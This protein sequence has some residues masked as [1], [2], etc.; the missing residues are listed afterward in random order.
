MQHRTPSWAHAFLVSIF[1][2]TLISPAHA[3]VDDFDGDS[4]HEDWTTELV[5][6]ATGYCCGVSGGSLTINPA[7]GGSW[8]GVTFERPYSADG[9]FD[10]SAAWSWTTGGYANIVIGV[11]AADGSEMSSIFSDSHT[12]C[13]GETFAVSLDGERLGIGHPACSGSGVTSIS[14]TGD[15]MTV[16]Y[17]GS[18]G[19]AS[20][21]RVFTV[22]IVAVQLRISEWNWGSVN[23]NVDR[24]EINCGHEPDADGDGYDALACG[25]FDC[26]DDNA[27]VY[28]DA[29]EVCDEVDNDCDGSIDEDPIDA[30]TWY[31]DG[32]GDGF[33]GPEVEAVS[34][35]A[36][37]GHVEDDTDCNDS[38]AS[39]SP[40]ADEVCDEVDNDC[41][42][43]TDEDDA[44]D[45]AT[46]YADADTD[47][48]GDGDSPYSACE[49]PPGFLAD[50]SD[51]DDGDDAVFPGADEA[52]DG[53]DNDCDGVTD[54]D[55]ASD[56]P[57]WYADADGD[58]YGD[59][60]TSD[61]A[62]GAPADHVADAT[63]C[64]DGVSTTFPGADEICDGVD[65]DC[66]GTTDGAGAIDAPTWYADHDGDGY[67]ASD[68]TVASCDEP[69]G[70][71][72]DATDCDDLEASTYPGADETCD[73]EDNDCD[74]VTDEEGATDVSTWYADTDGDGFG[75]AAVTHTACSLPPGHV[76]D[77]TDCDD[78]ESTTFPGADETCD[79]T[80]ND[81]D[82]V[83]DED[84][85]SDTTTWY[86]DADADGYGDADT[87]TDACS[88]PEGHVENNSDCDDAAA[89]IFP[90]AD[91]TCDG[92]DNDC[93]G[94]TDEDDALDA[95]TWYIDHDG[96][97][98]GSDDY[99]WVSCEAPDGYIADD[100]DC[101]DLFATSNPDA[102]ELC[103]DV[104]NDCDGAIDEDAVDMLI[105]F[106]DTDE[107]GF[108]DAES[109]IW[110]CSTP[111][112][113]V[114][115]DS[116]CDDSDPAS[117]PGAPGWTIDCE[118]I[119][120]G[121]T[122]D[123]GEPG[124]TGDSGEPGDT[125]DSGEPGDI[126]DS[127]EPGDTGQ[128]SGDPP[129]DEP[130]DDPGSEGGDTPDDGPDDTEDIA[131]GCGC[132]SVQQGALAPWLMFL[133]LVGAARMRARP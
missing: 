3:W 43:T 130:G 50:S 122:G 54:E 40:G 32:D 70:F 57:T 42:G 94:M 24:I 60:A 131:K 92:A 78:A 67:G 29:A 110:A 5:D 68:F 25:G 133:V 101:N 38:D 118:A 22:P 83:T 123:S 65:N 61:V 27:A 17:T 39:I 105:F 26:D 56:A 15:T 31:A 82:G 129:V 91:E 63:D 62:C 21:S 93:D 53:T 44:S 47:G 116:D 10:F 46:W 75:D 4:L 1:S 49:V 87:T 113:H 69:D 13:S 79:G 66:D 104:D 8:K 114:E 51:C 48:F 127:G 106:A 35:T 52:C 117:H 72:E 58:G 111:E 126:G 84:D 16:S 45:A 55:D 90:D 2:L 115:D 125:G 9:D 74:G 80:D 19:S 12:G 109:A 64:D 36:P 98:Y 124:D 11:I 30:P 119:V 77:A 14:R 86:A 128:D 73:G 85:A 71:V 121:D 99:T 107:D 108:G 103:D 59:M 89:A 81:C 34:C 95:P 76:E 132:A 88:A 112:G 28:P 6:V 100:T 23:V 18:E 7:G 41:D 102:D 96:D 20:L 97:G 33:G 37:A 120:V